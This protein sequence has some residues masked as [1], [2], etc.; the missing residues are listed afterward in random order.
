MRNFA[1][2]LLAATILT[3]CAAGADYT[4]PQTPT[5]GDFARR[6]AALYTAAEPEAAFWTVFDDPQL[7]RMV[8]DALTANTDIK[9]A[10]ARLD[11]ARALSRQSRFDL[12]PTVRAGGSAS[13]AK[14]AA[15]QT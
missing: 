11:E 8:E 9:V 5:S 4:A 3:A 6:D 10:V 7:S 12:L 1:A 2:A 13:A 14:T 15:V